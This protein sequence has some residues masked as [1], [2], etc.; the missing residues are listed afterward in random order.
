MKTTLLIPQVLRQYVDGQE[1]VE[2]SGDSVE[3]LLQN[4]QLVQ[5]KL[6]KCIC[7][8]TGA[9]RKHIHIFLNND[10]VKREGPQL[11][12]KPGDVV[13]VFQAVSGG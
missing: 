12:L 8:E 3:E 6:Y 7:N 9:V 13:S 10:L 1:G 4:L 5:P 2:L 11:R